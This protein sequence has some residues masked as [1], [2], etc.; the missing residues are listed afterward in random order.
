MI[1]GLL[2]LQIGY[3]EYDPMRAIY[4]AEKRD[5]LSSESYFK[6]AESKSGKCVKK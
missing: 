3:N 5:F 4:R 6:I 2:I 1:R